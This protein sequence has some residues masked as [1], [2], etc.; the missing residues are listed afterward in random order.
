MRWAWP[1]TSRHMTSTATARISR[2]PAATIATQTA[3]PPANAPV[4]ERKSRPPAAAADLPTGPSATRT[5]WSPPPTPSPPP[6]APAGAGPPPPP[7]PRLRVVPHADISADGAAALPVIAPP[8]R[9]ADARLKIVVLGAL[10]AIRGAA[11]LEAGALQ[12]A[13]RQAPV[14]FHLLGYGYRH[15]QTQP[16]ARLT[17]HGAY[18]DPDLPGLLH[19]LQPDLVWFPALWPETYSYT[20]SAALQAGLPVV[21]PDLGAFAERLAGRPW[22]RA[23]PRDTTPPH[24][25]PTFLA[26]RHRPTLAAPPAPHPP[27]QR[28]LA[29]PPALPAR[30]ARHRR[31]QPAGA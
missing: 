11:L 2:C 13:R 12:A 20:L 15:L 19:W 10:S 31:A 29:L 26:P 17:V 21:A 1:T 9:P 23:M 18:E 28:R 14:E 16:R 30:T 24:L 4:A 22:S 5:F 6:T 25:L 27:R 3:P 7:G 8:P